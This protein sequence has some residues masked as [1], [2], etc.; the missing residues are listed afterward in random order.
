MRTRGRTL[1]GAVAAL[2]AGAVFAPARCATVPDAMGCVPDP[3]RS[4]QVTVRFTVPSA[5][6]P[7]RGL[8]VLL[9]YP[10]GKVQVPRQGDEV[11]DGTVTDVPGIAVARDLGHGLREAI[12]STEPIPPGRLLVAHFQV[13]EGAPTPSSREF[14]CTIE[15]SSDDAGKRLTGLGCSTSTEEFSRRSTPGNVPPL[16]RVP[17][18]KKEK[19]RKSDGKDNE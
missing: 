9:G 15:D 16:S 13:C 10:R 18:D 7:V 1:G 6:P 4:Y 19:V 8:V 5:A 3:A 11:A 12:V 2:V 17:T 14:P